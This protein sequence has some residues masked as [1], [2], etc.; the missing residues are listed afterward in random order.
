M[1]YVFCFVVVVFCYNLN[2]HKKLHGTVVLDITM[3]YIQLQPRA[4][5]IENEKKSP[6]HV[7]Y[8]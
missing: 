1:S 6:E 5:H 2:K 8:Y 3:A 4:H 7:Y